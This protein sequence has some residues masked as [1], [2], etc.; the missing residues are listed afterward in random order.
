METVGSGL[1]VLAPFVHFRSLQAFLGLRRGRRRFIFGLLCA[2]AL[3]YLSG[4]RRIMVHLGR[5]GNPGSTKAIR[6][7]HMR[8]KR[9]VGRCPSLAA[10]Y[11]PTW[12]AHTPILQFVLLGLKELRARIL[13]RSPY[14]R[15]VIKLR[16]GASIALDWVAPATPCR[17]ANVSPVCVLLHGAIQD[18]ASATMVDLA[19]SLAARGM[20]VVV[21]NRRG[22][23]GI[24]LGVG[25]EGAKLTMFGF[26]EDLEDVLN[27]VSKRYPGAPVAIIGFSCGSGYC[28][29]FAGNHAHLSAWGRDNSASETRVRLLCSVCYDS[30]Y[31]VSPDGD[32][33]RVPPPY[34]WVL[35]LGLKYTY[36]FRHR[37]A[38]RK[39]SA[40]PDG[41]V[42][43]ALSLKKG[44]RETYREVRSLS[45][46]FG[47]SAWLDLQQPRLDDILVPSLMINSRDDPICTWANVVAF[48]K[49][50]AANPHVVLAELHRGAHG[51]KFDFWGWSSVTNTIIGDFVLA[52][53]H[54]LRST[55]S[56]PHAPQVC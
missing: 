19:K 4:V 30:L 14:I 38:I 24:C 11:W 16:D 18:S 34:S 54:E 47:S 55:C 9:I 56:P 37:E 6:D 15:E 39:H 46:T 22:Y 13:Q 20:P 43:R 48:S 40:A 42:E 44:L 25:D 28:G 41:L 3:H 52:S 50:I 36:V 23:G 51:C 7:A 8:M 5:G 10:V 21:M 17:D 31:D 29:R 33:T 49:D 27:V 53:W 2:W 26:D 45:G 12:Y 35:N 32:V 1:R